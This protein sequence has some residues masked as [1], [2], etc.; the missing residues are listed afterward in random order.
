M[1]AIHP[2]MIDAIVTK[3]GVDVGDS[4]TVTLQAADTKRRPFVSFVRLDPSAGS[5]DVRIG[6]MILAVNGDLYTGLFVGNAGDA[7]TLTTDGTAG[8]KR[9]VCT[10]GFL[11]VSGGGGDSGVQDS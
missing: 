10:F 9:Y 7:V 11:S 5:M 6:S 4:I 3:T 2:N 1:T 8:V